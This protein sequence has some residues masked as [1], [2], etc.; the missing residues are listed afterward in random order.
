VLDFGEEVAA[1]D[2][3]LAREVLASYEDAFN[4]NP[5]VLPDTPDEAA[6]EAW[7]RRVRAEFYK[8]EK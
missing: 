4:A 5:T 7:L 1:G 2:L 8:G 3:R 6:A